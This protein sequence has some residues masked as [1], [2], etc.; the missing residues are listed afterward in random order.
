MHSSVYLYDINSDGDMEYLVG[1]SLG[2]LQIFSD[3]LWDPSTVLNVEELPLQ[4]GQLHIY[5]NPARDYVV[6]TAENT[7]MANPKTEIYNIL[8]E[9]LSPEIQVL[10]NKVVI[11]TGTLP[12][13]LYFIRISDNGIDYTGKV[14]L[15]R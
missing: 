4:T 3:S 12:G 13:G 11:N 1:N 8:G 14:V 6:C 5:P 7:D 10:N 9:R 15:N 2:G